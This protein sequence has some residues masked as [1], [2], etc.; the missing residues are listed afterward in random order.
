TNSWD[1][2]VAPPRSQHPVQLVDLLENYAV[3]DS[4]CSHLDVAG[5]DTLRKVT[6]RWSGHLSAHLTE[7]WNI[8][9]KLRRFVTHPKEFRTELGYWDALISGS[10]ALQFF[11]GVVW[12]ESDLDI[13][14]EYGADATGLGEY[15]VRD[16]S[17]KSVKIQGHELL[18]D[19]LGNQTTTYIRSSRDGIPEKQTKIQIVAT[20][21]IPIQAIL[22]GFYTTAVV[23]IITWNKAYSV[24]PDCTFLERK[25]YMLQPLDDWFG[26][27]LVKYS[28]RGW[29]TLETQWEEDKKPSHSLQDSTQRRV[30]DS[31]TWTIALN[32]DGVETSLTP[33]Y[34]I[35][36]ACF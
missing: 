32:T 17:Y 29:M 11:D 12:E 15:L 5:I 13:F 7:R 36:Y 27:Q 6:K 8:N 31:H 9:K 16:E 30:G 20:R 21:G 4:L 24:F 18:T 35:E 26:A 3:F 2:R 1:N 22:R 14:V 28:S 19:T 34:V 23:N 25:T 10:F 33:D